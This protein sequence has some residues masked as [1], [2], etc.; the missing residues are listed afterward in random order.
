MIA[1]S[2]VT[3]KNQT[4]LPK[5]VVEALH[6]RPSDHLVYYVEQDQVILRTKSGR[7]IDLRGKFARSGQKAATLEEMQK[8]VARGASARCRHRRSLA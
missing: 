1:T 4:T 5:A 6:I 8:A 2:T 3:S 7:L